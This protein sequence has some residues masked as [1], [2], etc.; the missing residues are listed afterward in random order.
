L[1][2][3]PG[4]YF[5]DN[6]DYSGRVLFSAQMIPAE[7]AWIEAE[8]DANDV[9]YVR[10]GQTRKFPMTTLLR[11]LNSFD[12]EAAGKN[13]PQTATRKLHIDQSLAVANPAA[14]AKADHETE[15]LDG[16]RQV[17]VQ[18][19]YF[20]LESLN[21]RT[22]SIQFDT[23]CESFHAITLLANDAAGR[24]T[25]FW[26]GFGLSVVDAIRPIEPLHLTPPANFRILQATIA[27]IDAL[28]TI[29][30]EH[31][32]HY[33]TSPIF[34]QP[35]PPAT[36]LEFANFLQQPSCSA[37]LALDGDSPAAYLRFEPSSHGAAAIVSSASTTAIT[38][39]YVRPAYRGKRLTPALLDAA[40][41]EY[42]RQ[43]YERCSVDFESFNPE[44]AQFW[45]RYFQPV[46]Y[47]LMR[48]P[49]SIA[50]AG[51]Q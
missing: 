47:S 37:W 1:A 21:A 15:I 23:A 28:G 49:E 10:I 24:E 45:P 4:V 26:N 2:R 33:R 40:L 12:H 44:A 30:A 13:R 39:A 20:T 41:Q 43:G 6:I 32:Q 3:S 22:K 38:G 36:A 25:W 34:M 14:S 19:Q 27:E 50:R 7:G 35:P 5:R 18:C 46:C 17:R 48:V 9:V 16:S 11:A 8:M 31:W 42:Q 29:E 51:A